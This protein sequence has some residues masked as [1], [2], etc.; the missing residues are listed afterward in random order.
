M[1]SNMSPATL[2]SLC[3]VLQKRTFFAFDINGKR[4]RKKT[5][6]KGSATVK[7]FRPPHSLERPVFGL[8]RPFVFA[9]KDL[10]WGKGHRFG[11]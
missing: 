7:K 1:L 8:K 9:K 11:T 4:P 3:K 2:S 10:G 5:F 6:N